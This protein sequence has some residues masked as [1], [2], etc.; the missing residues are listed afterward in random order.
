[1]TLGQCILLKKKARIKVR[2][3]AVLIGTADIKVIQHSETEFRYGQG[4]LKEGEVFI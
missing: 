3:A 1:M 2:D 4:I